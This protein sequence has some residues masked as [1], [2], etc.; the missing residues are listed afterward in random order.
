MSQHRVRRARSGVWLTVV[1]LSTGLVACA[2]AVPGAAQLRPPAGARPGRTSPTA[3][4]PMTPTPMTPTPMTPVPS[5]A[6]TAVPLGPTASSP[7]AGSP[8]AS[9]PPD[10]S[11]PAGVAPGRGGAPAASSPPVAPA[12]GTDGF[13]GRRIVAYYGAPGSASLGVLGSGTPAQAWAQLDARAA[14]YDSP[15]RPAVRC[16]ELIA[17]VASDSAG[18][19]GLYR[20][21][22]STSAIAPYLRTVRAHGGTLLLDIQPGRSD[23]LDEAKALE[24]WLTQPDVGLA[25]DPEWRMGPGQVPGK[26]IGSVSAAEVDSV[27]SWLEDLTVAR[28]LPDKLFV[29]HEF[30]EPELQDEDDLQ[31]QPHLHEIVNVDGF[32]SVAVKLSVYH[33]LARLSPF[34]TGLKLFYRQDPVLMAPRAVLAIRPVPQLVDY[35]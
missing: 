12:A 15:G 17:T 19:D 8:P 13:A 6:P 4:T 21:R 18:A 29:V 14:A 26:E 9:S 33:R 7:A 30:T 28:H 23:F 2:Q 31:N 3:P 22:L 10:S 16:F 34:A 25:L 32:G 20:N 35:Q 24:P 1:V 27:S 11:P 5:G